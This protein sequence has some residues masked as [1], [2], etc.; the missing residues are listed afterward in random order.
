ME[1]INNILMQHQSDLEQT[2]FLKTTKN[3]VILKA[4]AGYGKTKVLT[5]KIELII[6]KNELKANKKILAL[7]YSVNAAKKMKEDI[8]LSICK[9]YKNRLC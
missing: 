3:R 1:L 4:P 2:N 8:K 9:D 6:L 7:T 5:S